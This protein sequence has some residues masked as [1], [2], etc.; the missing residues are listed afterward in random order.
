MTALV[1]TVSFPVG[2]LDY[3]SADEVARLLLLKQDAIDHVESRPWAPPISEVV[4]AFGLGP[5][6]ALFLVRFSRPLEGELEGETEM[7]IVVGDLP[8]IIFDTELCPTP[9]LA[10]KLYSCIAEDWADNVL[11][12]EDFSESYPIGA[13]PT[14]QHA[15]MLKDRMAFVREKLIPMAGG[16]ALPDDDPI[17]D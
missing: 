15:H 4:L 7:W 5:I 3:E 6:A 13:A 10:L 16:T 9:A 1:D 2:D 8:T 12:G 11:R 14:E 17:S